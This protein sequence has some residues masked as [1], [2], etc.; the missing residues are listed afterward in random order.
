MI[1]EAFALLITEPVYEKAKVAMH[2]DYGYQHIAADAEGGDAA[3]KTEKQADTAE[4]LGADG[5]ESKSRRNVH[6]LSEKA[7]SAG[8]TIAAK[9]TESFLRT[10][11]E[12]DDAKDEAQDGDSGIVGGIDELTQHE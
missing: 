6:A 7:H 11:S 4:K 1:L 3:E 10:V 12:K 2:H 8:E 9:P 5:Q